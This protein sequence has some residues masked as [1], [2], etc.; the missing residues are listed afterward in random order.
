[1][2]NQ[3]GIT[4]SYEQKQLVNKDLLNTLQPLITPNGENNTI[5]LHQDICVDTSLLSPEG[6]VDYALNATRQLWIHVATGTV[7]LGD[8][9]LEAGDGAGFCGE[10]NIT[11]K[12][13]EPAEVLWFNLHNPSA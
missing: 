7:M 4:P 11:I 3:Q 1:M 12:A 13:L 5:T 8:E 9:V 10:Q 2:P 6:Q